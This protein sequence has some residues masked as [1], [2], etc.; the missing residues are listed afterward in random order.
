MELSRFA[1][2]FVT[3]E[4]LKMNRFEVGLNPTI[5]ERMSVRRYASYIDLYDIAANM[6]R[7]MKER[8]NYFNE[9][10]GTKRNEDNWGGFQAPEQNR[11]LAGGQYSNN[12]IQGGLYPNIRHK[13]T[14][15]VC[16][17][18]GH[19]GRKCRSTKRCF[20]YGSHQHQVQDCPLLP[21][22]A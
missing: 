13:V 2:T 19:F 6:E 10:R 17:K 4:R 15:N 5:K 3:N 21:P 20:R 8:N 7:A 9:Q 16:G 14:C 22:R 1:P 12:F 18:P 11:R